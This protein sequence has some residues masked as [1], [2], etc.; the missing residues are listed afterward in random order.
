MKANHRVW[1]ADSA[2]CAG[3]R[4]NKLT[5]CHTATAGPLQGKS[6]H[7]APQTYGTG[8]RRKREQSKLQLKAIE[9]VPLFQSHPVRVLDSLFFYFFIGG[10]WLSKTPSGHALELWMSLFRTWLS[11]NVWHG[12]LCSCVPACFACANGNLLEC[13]HVCVYALVSC[14]VINIW[15]LMICVAAL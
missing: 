7:V 14:L 15:Y 12:G 13:M 8:V 6:E 2:A 11:S 4:A 3:S 10:I 5:T 1:P 9:V